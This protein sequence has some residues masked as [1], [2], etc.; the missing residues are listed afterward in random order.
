M[1]KLLIIKLMISSTLLILKVIN[2]LKVTSFEFEKN[3]NV[4]IE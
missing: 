3:K 1:E 2:Y 4:P